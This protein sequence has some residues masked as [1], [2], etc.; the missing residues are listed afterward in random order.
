MVSVRAFIRHVASALFLTP[1]FPA[2]ASACVEQ[3]APNLSDIRQADAIVVASVKRYEIVE[4]TDEFGA[5]HQ[6][7]LL[8]VDVKKSLKGHNAGQIDLIFLNSTFG[9]PQQLHVADPAIIAI[10]E[11]RNFGIPKGNG[12]PMKSY[13][14]IVWDFGCSGI[15]I[16]PFS[17]QMEKFVISTITKKTFN[18]SE[19]KTQE[20]LYSDIENWR[21]VPGIHR[22]ETLLSTAQ[23]VALSILILA[24]LAIVATW[25][26]ARR[27][28]TTAN[29]D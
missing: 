3:T 25:R 13:L 29:P 20:L 19:E 6:Y 11:N 18:L 9:L 12:L 4:Y 5:S 27:R 8:A 2:L 21:D 26:E 23:M 28:R 1:M 7:G 17:P 15:S 14:P 22:R 24:I 16:L 10:E